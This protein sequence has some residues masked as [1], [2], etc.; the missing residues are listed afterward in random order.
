MSCSLRSSSLVV[1]VEFSLEHPVGDTSFALEQVARLINQFGKF[2]RGDKNRKW[3]EGQL[4]V[5]PVLRQ[6]Q[7][8]REVLSL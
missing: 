6:A 5:P 3:N 1:Y 2:H 8:E 4:G 7:D